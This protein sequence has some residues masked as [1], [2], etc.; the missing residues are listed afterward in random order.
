MNSGETR[1]KWSCVGHTARTANLD[2]GIG[3]TAAHLSW[4]QCAGVGERWNMQVTSD[5]P[6][7]RPESFDRMISDLVA[8]AQTI[9][10]GGQRRLLG[11]TG[12]P[13]SGKSTVCAALDDA[14]GV[15][16]VVVGMDGFHLS[17][18]E[19]IRM[20]RLDRK[21]A[22]DTFDVD[23]YAA[24][25][26]RLRGQHTDVIYA[27]RFDR[28]LEQ[29]IGSAIAVSR[30]TPLVVTEGN[31]LLM[32]DGG[33]ENVVPSL[34]EVWYLD[35]AEDVRARRLI[36]RQRGHG[37]SLADAQRW[38]ET[39]D[40]PNSDFSLGARSRADLIVVVPDRPS[41]DGDSQ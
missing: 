15:D 34:D 20:S 16:S 25:L 11:I 3:G 33:W 29:S 36:D 1:D 19:L 14:L 38:T 21:G 17:N 6:V 12:P 22:P 8:R 4:M 31:Y 10:S 35:V 40:L 5:R 41:P 23:G 24:L 2:T 9:V 18:E 39:V 7:Y 37:K 30:T 27:P 26:Q 32:P 13:G 28:D